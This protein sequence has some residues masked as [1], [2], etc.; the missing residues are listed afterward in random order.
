MFGAL[1]LWI[2]L[3][4]EIIKNNLP[5]HTGVFPVKFM[6]EILFFK[7]MKNCLI[8]LMLLMISLMSNFNNV[9]LEEVDGRLDKHSPNLTPIDYYLWGYVKKKSLQWKDLGHQTFEIPHSKV[10]TLIVTYVRGQVWEDK[11]RTQINNK[12]TFWSVIYFV[13]LFKS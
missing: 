3:F 8:I 13:Q 5:W 6:N 4:A 2:Y 1:L 12:N 10:V 7:K 9:W 11:Y